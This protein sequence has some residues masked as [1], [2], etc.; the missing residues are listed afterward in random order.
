MAVTTIT[1][2]AIALDTDVVISQ[3]AGTAI[4]TSNTMEIAYPKQGKLLIIVDSD[5]AS[6]AA[7]FTAGVGVAK[8]LGALTW[9]IGDTKVG[10]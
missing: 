1:P 8:D 3:G 5:H 6:T 10:S 2:T 9:A 7:V 4:N